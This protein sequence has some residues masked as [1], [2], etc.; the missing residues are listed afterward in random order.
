MDPR[1]QKL[2]KFLI[3]AILI[4]ANLWVWSDIFGGCQNASVNS[5]AR[6]RNGEYI[7]ELLDRTPLDVRNLAQHIMLGSKHVRNSKQQEERT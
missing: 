5:S 2:V 4:L 1:V 7:V 6:A 3:F